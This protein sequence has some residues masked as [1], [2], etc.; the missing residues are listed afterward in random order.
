MPAKSLSLKQLRDNPLIGCA[1]DNYKDNDKVREIGVMRC[2]LSYVRLA[3]QT[4]E[5]HL[6]GPSRGGQHLSR[7]RQ[8]LHYLSHVCFGL[9]YTEIAR[10]TA[11][12][13]TSVA[14]GCQKIEDL[15]DDPSVDKRL[16]FA[17]LAVVSL[18][19]CSLPENDLNSL[20]EC[21]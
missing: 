3:H 15:R 13:R 2:V 8:T 14:H 20:P 18:A 17:E 1:K 21:P 5:R 19:N 16:F 7:A 11:R 12:D 9:T 4:P 10:L 6:L